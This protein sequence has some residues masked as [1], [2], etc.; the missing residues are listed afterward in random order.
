MDSQYIRQEGYVEYCTDCDVVCF[1]F[2]HDEHYSSPR[3][4]VSYNESEGFIM[5][6]YSEYSFD[7]CWS[8]TETLCDYLHQYLLGYIEEGTVLQ[9]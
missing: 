5:K 1:N 8:I 7:Y 3:I 9:I 6:P 4:V 2:C